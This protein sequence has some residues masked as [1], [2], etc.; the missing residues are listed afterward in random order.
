MFT[1]CTNCHLKIFDHAAVY[2][3]LYVNN[4]VIKRSVPVL[5]AAGGRLRGQKALT[6]PTSVAAEAGRRKQHGLAKY[7]VPRA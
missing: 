1:S 3:F 4:V 2:V 6:P 7:S 5:P